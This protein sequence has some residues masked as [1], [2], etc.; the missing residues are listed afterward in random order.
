MKKS[1]SPYTFKGSKQ[2]SF[3][4]KRALSQP[5]FGGTLLGKSHPKVARKIP[6][7][8]PIHLVLR[9]RDAIKANFLHEHVRV[10]NLILKQAG[11]THVEV[12]E[13]AIHSNHIHLLLKFYD[14]KLYAQFIRGLTGR[15]ARIFL[16]SEKGRPSRLGGFW[17]GR[18]YTKI[19]Q[20]FHQWRITAQYLMQNRIESLGQTRHSAQIMLKRIHELFGGLQLKPLGFETMPSLLKPSLL[21]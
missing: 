17:M 11:C 12:Q 16:K 4:F 19:V 14:S 9:R 13:M 15:L 1:Q 3:E 18:P 21:K 5:H 7:K 8:C 6:V 10:Q 2:G 20:N